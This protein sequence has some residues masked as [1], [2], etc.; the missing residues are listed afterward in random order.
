MNW[1]QAVTIVMG[2]GLALIAWRLLR[3]PL[4]LLVTERGIL[5]RRLR[6]GWI[7]WDEIE[8]AYQ[9]TARD[10]EALRLRLRVTERSGRTLWRRRAAR[11]GARSMDVRLDL[12]GSGF[13]AVELLQQILSR[14]AGQRRDSARDPDSTEL[15]PAG[16]RS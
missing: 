2:A 3:P 13:T 4:R 8:G 15:L 10:G 5:D 6:L 11:R 1:I 16:P 12:S 14:T 7:H 9:P